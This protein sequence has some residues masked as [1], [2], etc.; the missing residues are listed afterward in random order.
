[1]ESSNLKES[2]RCAACLN[3]LGDGAGDGEGEGEGTDR[4]EALGQLWHRD[5]FRCSGCDCALGSWYTARG[6]L[7][8]CRACWAESGGGAGGGACGRCGAAVSGPVLAAGEL[9]YHPECFACH[10]CGAYLE[11]TEPYALI[12]R[13][14]LYCGACDSARAGPD[15]H[16]IRV[17]RTPADVRLAALPA[18]DVIF[19]QVPEGCGVVAGDALLEV[20]GVGTRGVGLGELQRAVARAARLTVEHRPA[21]PAPPPAPAAPRPRRAPRRAPPCRASPA[22]PAP[23][24]RCRSMSKLLDDSSASEKERER[25]EEEGGLGRCASLRADDGA[26]VFRAADLVQGELLGAGFFGRAYKVTHRDTREVMVLKQLHRADERAQRDFLREVGVLRSLRHPNVLRFAGVLYRAGRLHLVTEYVAG[27][28]LRA[29]LAGER[30]LGWAARARLARDVAAGVAYLHRRAVIHRDLNSHNCLV[31]ERGPHLSVVVADFGL[32][33][34]VRRAGGQPAPGASY[35][36]L[37]RKRYTVVGNPYWMAPEMM[38]GNVYDEKVDVFSFGIVLCEIIGRVSADPDVLPRRADFGLHE[39]AFVDKFC[40]DCPEPLYRAAFLACDLDPDARPP[41]SVLEEWLERLVS[42]LTT[43]APDTLLADVLRYRGPASAPAAAL[44]VADSAPADAADA[45]V[46]DAQRTE[47]PTVRV[48]GVCAGAG[49]GGGARLFALGKCVSA[50]ALA[51]PA[52]AAPAPRSRSQHALTPAYILSEDGPRINITKVEDVSEWLEPQPAPRA[53]DVLRGRTLPAFCRN[54]SEDGLTCRARD[55]PLAP[56]P[57]SDTDSGDESLADE[58]DPPVVAEVAPGPAERPGFL[59]KTLLGPALGRLLR[60]SREA[61]S[62]PE[63][64][65]RSQFFVQSPPSL[66][67]AH[68]VRPADRPLTPPLRRA[69]P[70]APAP[71]RAS[72][73]ERRY[74]PQRARARPGAVERRRARVE[75]DRKHE[76]DKKRDVSIGRGNYVNLANL[77]KDAAE[78][79]A[80]PA[81]PVPAQ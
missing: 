67:A 25:E 48:D 44:A 33:R 31:R 41:V 21:A 12:E 35:A 4:V 37:R 26:R 13:S 68:R 58:A 56:A 17:V 46:A 3:K 38:N 72:C 54:Q 60:P 64:R 49:A 30:P 42:Q 15:A 9:R 8:L 71:E 29:L 61:S 69:A 39:A 40:R 7:P 78:R 24:Q 5:C 79:P 53:D 34:V 52:S 70:A 10:A 22:S 20:E 16:A 76:P 65:A 32:A 1:M 6:E 80:P 73:R 14:R 47:K 77:A 11:D 36:S 2:A 45:D 18:G 28:T 63:R 66:R 59:A 57:P 62:E 50:S 23:G 55:P 27:G 75:G 43:G 51:P 19:T 74:D 81:A